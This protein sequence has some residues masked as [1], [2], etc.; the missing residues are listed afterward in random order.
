MKIRKIR[1]TNFRSVKFVEVD[2]DK[3]RQLLVGQ[4]NSGKSN[5]LRA[6]DCVFNNRYVVSENDIYVHKEKDGYTLI[7]IMISTS[8]DENKFSDD[9]LPIFGDYIK[10]NEYLE[11]SYSIRCVIKENNITGKPE[12][13]KFPLLN[14]DSKEIESKGKTLPRHFRKCISTFHVSSNRDILDELRIKS[15]NFSQLLKNSNFSLKNE[16]KKEIEDRLGEINELITSK[17][18]DIS[19][20]ETKL[21]Q[22]TTSIKNMQSI[23]ILPIPN[24]LSDIDKG[25]EILV[26][27]NENQLPISI[28]G[29]GTRSWLSI[30]SL[31]SFIEVQRHQNKLEGLPFLPILLIEEPEA[32]LHPHAEKKVI[33]QLSSIESVIFITTHSVNVLSNAQSYQIIRLFKE[34]KETK[35]AIIKENDLDENLNYKYKNQIIPYNTDMFFSEKTILVEGITDKIFLENYYKFKYNKNLNEIGVSVIETGGYGGL[36]LFRKF[37]EGFSIDSIIIADLDAKNEVE[38]AIEKYQLSKNKVYFTKKNEL[39][40]D[41][42]NENF[43]IVLKMFSLEENTSENYIKNLK[44]NNKLDEKLLKYLK[45]GK[46]KYPHIINKYFNET[47]VMSLF[48]EINNLLEGE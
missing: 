30:L 2:L 6:I 16:D 12:I 8:N 7:D 44:E 15:S 9:W 3:E 43:D 24:R 35:L 47:F 42:L 26:N 33:E 28:Y 13:E 36:G 4:N 41:I 10:E 31:K 18:P 37:C 11:D 46:T 27:E 22:I 19:Q 45:N 5:L 48:D 38:S 21:S 25:V 1:L 20:I 23:N 17:L 32:N 39:E 34:Q 40:E 29:D 14:W